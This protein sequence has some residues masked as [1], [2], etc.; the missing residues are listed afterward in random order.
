MFWKSTLSALISTGLLVVSSGCNQQKPHF[1]GFTFFPN[2][3]ELAAVYERS[4]STFIYKIPTDGGTATRFTHNAS[5]FEGIPAFSKD[6]KHVAYPF[7]PGEKIQ[8]QIMIANV[9]G[10]GAIPL[11]HSEGGSR[12][13]FSPDDKYIVFARFSFYGNYSPI[14]QPAAHEWIFYTEDMDNNN[15]RQLTN[16]EFY[17]VS[18]ASISPDGKSL[19]FVSSESRGDTID[20]YSLEEPQK[21][22]RVLIP[23]VPGEPVTPIF[24]DPNFSPDGQKMF[25]LAASNGRSA[26]DY[27]VYSIDLKTNKIDKLTSDN[28]YSYGMQLSPDGKKAI[29][30]RDVPH[31]YGSKQVAL[32]LDLQ[33]CGIKQL[34]ITGLE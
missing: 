26:F 1:E 5:G 7:S 23:H 32:L 25:F 28:G 17:M 19:A 13:Q 8:S 20:I 14:A 18:S 29:F 31:W 21:P 2:G 4:G 22:K 27:D 24:N 10:T 6:G 9:D 11:P 12:I 34:S 33:T 16:E 3:R 30:M 15:V